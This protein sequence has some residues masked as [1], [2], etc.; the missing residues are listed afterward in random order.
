MVVLEMMG[1]V[2]S[3]RIDQW[4]LSFYLGW[5][6]DNHCNEKYTKSKNEAVTRLLSFA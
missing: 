4:F 2:L 6:V 5:P 3:S 1:S